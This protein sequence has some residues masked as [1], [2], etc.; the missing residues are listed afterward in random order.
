MTEVSV[1]P[2]VKDW[3]TVVAL[4]A[5]LLTPIVLLWL[6]SQFASRESIEK[7]TEKF[8]AKD[9]AI[10]TAS[11]AARLDI[12][13]DRVSRV[14]GNV[15]HLPDKDETHKMALA[16]SDMRG[17]MKAISERLTPIAATSERLQEF[18]LEQAK[19]R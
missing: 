10:Q 17:E 18:L 13:E 14:E 5:S 3:L 7:L 1:L 11:L 6:K 4:C 12:L 19:N 2:A 8:A 15:E 9:V 16:I